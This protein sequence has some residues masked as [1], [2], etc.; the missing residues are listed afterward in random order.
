MG[1]SWR[2]GSESRKQ[3]QAL[4][5]LS[6]AAAG[7][8][9]GVS[10]RR[11]GSSPLS[12]VRRSWGSGWFLSEVA[13]V[14]G[15]TAEWLAGSQR[16]CGAQRRLFRQPTPEWGVCVSSRS[17]V[18]CRCQLL[19]FFAAESFHGSANPRVASFLP[20]SH[21]CDRSRARSLTR[22]LGGR[23]VA[24]WRGQEGHLSLCSRGSDAAC[25]VLREPLDAAGRGATWALSVW[26]CAHGSQGRGLFAVGMVPFCHNFAY[27]CLWVCRSHLHLWFFADE[28]GNVQSHSWKDR[29][30]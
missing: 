2:Q 17:R 20:E 22:S 27:C 9:S 15:I 19:I 3:G 28:P 24:A 13:E 26:C 6:R 16:V 14:W 8:A 12:P 11:L 23:C 10:V 30:S 29:F 21:Q 1:A 7:P 5:G 4:H 18:T 25:L